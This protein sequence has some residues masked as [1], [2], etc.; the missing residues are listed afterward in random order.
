MF[1]VALGRSGQG[2]TLELQNEGGAWW[3]EGGSQSGPIEQLLVTGLCAPGENSALTVTPV[4]LCLLVSSRAA[5]F[6]G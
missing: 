4:S 6:C 3:W 5:V 2:P 1:I